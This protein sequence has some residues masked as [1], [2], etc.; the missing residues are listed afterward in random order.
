MACMQQSENSSW[1]MVLS[2]YRVGFRDQT[3]VLGLAVNALT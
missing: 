2:Q 1:E 3:Q